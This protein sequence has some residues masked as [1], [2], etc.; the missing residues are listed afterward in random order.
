MVILIV[1]ITLFITLLNIYIAIKIWQLRQLIAKITTVII[2]CN[3]YFYALLHNTP[4]LIYQGQHK[5]QH[6]KSQ[7]QALQL[8]LQQIRQIILLL[9]WSYRL[10]RGYFKQ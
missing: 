7:Y 3:L 6:I 1:A 5:I 10:W 8:Q 9:N 2:N 4:Q